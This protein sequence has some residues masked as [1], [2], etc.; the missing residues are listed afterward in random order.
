MHKILNLQSENVKRLVAVDITPDPTGNVIVIG[1]KNGAGKSSVLDSIEM[2]LNGT[3]SI[4]G[5]PIRKGQEKARIVVDLG[6]L[7]VKR[8]FT[9]GNSR[10]VV[11]NKQGAVFKSP[12]SVLDKLTG[13]LS[14]DPLAFMRMKPNEQRVT[15]MDLLGLDFT[16]QD[17]ERAGHYA[18][19]TQANR[20]AKQAEAQAAGIT[21]PDG[22]PDEFVDILSIVAEYERATAANQKVTAALGAA[23]R[24]AEAASMAANQQNQKLIRFQKEIDA[25]REKI[26]VWET[27]YKSGEAEAER[28]TSAAL[29]AHELF[30]KAQA[31]PLIDTSGLTSKIES[32]K[33]VNTHV[34]AK[35]RRDEFKKTMNEKKAESDTLTNSIATID[36]A[37]DAAIKA[38][39]FPV[40]GLGFDESGV[41][42][43]ELPMDQA[44][45]AEQLRVSVAMGFSMNPDLR[46]MLIRDGS[47]L[48]DDSMAILAGMAKDADAQ[49]WIERVGEGG[50]S[51]IIE[52]GA[53]KAQEPAE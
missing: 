45:S 1:G 4:P 25:L 46:I 23:D 51:V 36:A 32:A 24:T 26:A 34:A 5:K 6:D 40:P 11:E 20:D 39:P 35:L 43:N 30:K 7:V 52:D 49:V 9:E 41:L 8:I 48:D 16:D 21:Y 27:D 42:L 14:F 10:L 28:L 29:E 17:A 15:L 19:R 44:S 13:K 2:A 38:A 12:Q 37:K 3:E 22:T 18:N 47:L 53:V 31:E 50:A 33:I